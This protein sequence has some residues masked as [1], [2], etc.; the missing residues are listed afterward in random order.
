[1]QEAKLKEAAKQKQKELHNSKQDAHHYEQQAISS[2]MRSL[3][4]SE[5]NNVATATQLQA[6]SPGQE[7]KNWSRVI[8]KKDQKRKQAE[9]AKQEQEQSLP[10][11]VVRSPR[12]ISERSIKEQTPPQS[13]ALPPT[14]TTEESPST[15]LSKSYNLDLSSLLPQSAKL[16]QKQRKRLSSESQSWRANS[17][18]NLELNTTPV[19]VPNAWGVTPAVP[20]TY[21]DAFS[22]PTQPATGSISDPTSF[23]NM[24]RGQAASSINTQPEQGNSFSK[25]LADEKRQRESYDRMRNKSLVHTQ[26]EETAIAELREFYN[27]DRIDDEHITIERK[28]RPSNINFSTWTRH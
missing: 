25:I 16:S 20:T 11:L 14:P 23:A 17:S 7:A 2:M 21:P 26:I 1:M 19:A 28:S 5:D 4:V 12:T 18:A 13:T 24:M 9:T 6:T 10:E 8:D 22:S 15:P 3:S 27:V